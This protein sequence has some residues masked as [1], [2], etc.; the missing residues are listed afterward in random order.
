VALNKRDQRTMT[1]T[2]ALVLGFVVWSFGIEPVWQ[3]YQELNDT[4]ERE[5][6]KYV[7]NQETLKEAKAIEEGYERV[8]AQ[9]PQDD[10]ERDP[11]EVFNE[12]VVDLVQETI[13][14]YPSYS[15]PTTAEIKGATGYEF[16]ILPLEVKTTLGKVATLLQEFDKRGYL[17]QAATISRDS[18]LDKDELD[19][20]LNLGR[21]VKIVEEEEPVRRPGSLSLGQGR[22]R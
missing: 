16:L 12:E 14:V 18:D 9:F 4:L 7:Q 20:R 15:P 6:E 22:G 8:E 13:D 1:I 11:S 19:V 3:K 10:P 21:I 5:Q 17:I 2:L